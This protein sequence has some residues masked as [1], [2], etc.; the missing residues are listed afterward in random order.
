MIDTAIL[1]TNAGTSG[2]VRLVD[3]GDM[4]LQ[5]LYSTGLSLG[6]L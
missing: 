1:D 2:E 6:N 4:H 3:G 5:K